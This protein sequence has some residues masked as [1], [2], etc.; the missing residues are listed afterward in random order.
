MF[1]NGNGLIRLPYDITIERNAE[2]FVSRN[3][4]LD[5]GIY[6]EYE[7]CYRIMTTNS[8]GV[9]S[10]LFL[11][12]NR[13]MSQELFFA[14]DTCD[15]LDLALKTGET[16]DYWLLGTDETYKPISLFVKTMKLYD[17][18][19]DEISENL[20]SNIRFE[21]NFSKTKTLLFCQLDR[22]TI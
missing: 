3:I 8:V 12:F 4:Y 13:N 11:F 21:L 2:P 1:T 5:L 20:V 14:L 10:Y 7:F 22:Q 19:P 15:A 18:T 16:W 6:H 9:D 17:R